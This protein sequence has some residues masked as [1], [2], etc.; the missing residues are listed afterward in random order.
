MGVSLIVDGIVFK[1]VIERQSGRCIEH[2]SP[3]LRVVNGWETENISVIRIDK[4]STKERT[5]RYVLVVCLERDPHEP[6]R[7]E[8]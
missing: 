2:W 8:M 3:G 6:N 5:D 1:L 4:M 7:F